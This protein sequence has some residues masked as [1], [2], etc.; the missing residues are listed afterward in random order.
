M[1]NIRE[2]V[3]IDDV[4]DVYELVKKVLKKE[5]DEYDITLADSSKDSISKA[6]EVIPSL[7][8]INGD[9]IDGGLI[10]TCEF[11]RKNPE[12]RITPVIVASSNKDRDYRIEVLKRVVEYFIPKPLHPKYFYYTIKNLSRL[13]DA[14]RC[15]SNLT[16]LPGNAQIE[17]ELK[18]RVSGKKLFAVLY[19]D[20]DNFKAY[21]DKYGFM[22]GDEVIKFTANCLKEAMQAYGEKGDF[23]GHIGGDD[24]VAVCEYES[25]RK[26]GKDIIKKFNANIGEFYSEEDNENGYIRLPNRKGKMEK[27]PLMTLT[28]A[29]ISNKYKRYSSVLELGE[30]GA[31]VK[32]KAKTIPGS[33]F[34]ENRRK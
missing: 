26:I 25:A 17:I 15:I 7:I 1:I 8:I 19:A 13:I 5:C 10:K 22:N 18:K 33:T 20:L 11:V 29:M 12:N 27:Y 32:K 2:I 34:L 28:V 31:Q 3:V 24:F 4:G 21:N 30:D 16:G 6:L 14:N 23:L 9:D